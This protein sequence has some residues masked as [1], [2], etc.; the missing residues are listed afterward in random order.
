MNWETFHNKFIEATN[1][2]CHS[3]KDSC[4]KGEG[5]VARIKG[6]PVAFCSHACLEEWEEEGNK[7]DEWGCW[8]HKATITLL[9]ETIKLYAY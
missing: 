9:K 3:C 7:T 5:F 8:T 6:K 1:P 2:D 4:Y